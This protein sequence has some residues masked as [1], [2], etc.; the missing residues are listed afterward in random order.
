MTDPE[1]SWGAALALLSFVA[2]LLLARP[3]RPAETSGR[4]DVRPKAMATNPDSRSR[5]GR[6][7]SGRDPAAP[8]DR[9][10]LFRLR[11]ILSALAFAAGWTVLGGV[12]G[13]LAG[14]A[15]GWICYRT[16]ARAEGP[17][18]RRRRQELARDLPVGVDLLAA[19]VAAGGAVEQGL[20][21]V[22]TTLPGALAEELLRIH[23]RLALGADPVVVWRQVAAR[24]G[25]A[26]QLAP[27]GRAMARTHESGAPVAESILALGQEL[28]DR[29]RFEI[30]ARAKS[31]DVK[32]AG[33]LGVCLLPAFVLVGIVPLVAGLLRATGLFW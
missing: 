19:T 9:G 15:A 2:V 25:A 7:P 33:P 24:S 26:A 20:V 1:S 13:L 6:D 23:H 18:A 3:S 17:A 11:W 8:A 10:L 21:L 22:A 4:L 29:A 12:P 14:P 16:L 5:I 32:S 28:R 30:E 31:V 27:L